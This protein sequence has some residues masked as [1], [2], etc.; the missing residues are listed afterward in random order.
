MAKYPTGYKR[1]LHDIA[2]TSPKSITHE[3]LN[4]NSEPQQ[5]GLNFFIESGLVLH[6][7]NDYKM[8]SVADAA[9]IVYVLDFGGLS[10]HNWIFNVFI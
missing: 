8:S 4:I 10:L 6:D 9:A 1:I 7:G 5:E 2:Y 3:N